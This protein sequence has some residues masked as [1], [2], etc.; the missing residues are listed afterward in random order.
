[1]GRGDGF[2]FLGEASYG[3]GRIT[4]GSVVKARSFWVALCGLC[5]ASE[6]DQVINEQTV[7]ADSVG[8]VGSN[9]MPPVACLVC[10]RGLP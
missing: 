7:R 5:I 2:L 1:M 4:H 3:K 10:V 6:L 9:E 8:G